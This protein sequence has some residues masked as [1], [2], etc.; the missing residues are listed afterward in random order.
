MSM[1]C[2]VKDIFRRSLLSLHQFCPSEK[3]EDSLMTSY[4]L[5]VWTVQVAIVDLRQ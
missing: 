1:Y 3:G 4:P 5:D 2:V